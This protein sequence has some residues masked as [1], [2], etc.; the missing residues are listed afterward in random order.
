M[1]TEVACTDVSTCVSSSNYCFGAIL[2]LLPSSPT[3]PD[4]ERFG[5]TCESQMNK[6]IS[7]FAHLYCYIFLSTSN[8]ESSLPAPSISALIRLIRDIVFEHLADSGCEQRATPV[9]SEHSC[10]QSYAS[11]LDLSHAEYSV[12]RRNLAVQSTL[13]RSSPSAVLFNICQLITETRFLKQTDRSES[14]LKKL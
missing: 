14:I 3:G 1:T 6:L 8:P 12:T 11:S 4:Q 7:G 2:T 9:L 13:Q 5:S 10:A